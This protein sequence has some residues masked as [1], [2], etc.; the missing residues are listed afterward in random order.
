M[1][2]LC[3]LNYARLKLGGSWLWNCHEEEWKSRFSGSCERVHTEL[4]L[5]C[6]GV[7]VVYIAVLYFVGRVYELRYDK[8]QRGYCTSAALLLL[9]E[10]FTSLHFTSHGAPWISM[11]VAVL[12]E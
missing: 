3:V 5:V 11:C 4:F 6:A 8:T 9:D 7:V 12:L 2:I 10:H 1:A